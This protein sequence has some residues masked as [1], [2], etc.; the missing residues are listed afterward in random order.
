MSKCIAHNDKQ[1]L[2]ITLNDNAT[3]FDVT[4]DDL[5]RAIAR[6]KSAKIRETKQRKHAKSRDDAFARMSFDELNEIA[7]KCNVNVDDLIVNRRK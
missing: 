3:T 5:I 4:Y 6:F 1:T 7:K 2:T